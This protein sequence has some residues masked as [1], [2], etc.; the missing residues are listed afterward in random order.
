[1]LAALDARSRGAAACGAARVLLPARCGARRGA[2]RRP[3]RARPAGRGRA[4]RRLGA[5]RGRD[6][7]GRRPRRGERPTPSGSHSALGRLEE[8]ER[9]GSTGAAGARGRTHSG[10]PV[11]LRIAAPAQLGDLWQHG[12]GSAAHNAALRERAVRTRAAR[13]GV[14][15]RRRRGGATRTYATEAEVYG[16]LGLPYIEPELRED[17]GELEAQGPA[18]PHRAGRRA[19]RPALPHRR[20]R[21]PRH[22]RGDG[23]RGPGARVRV[24][25]DHRPLR[26]ARLRQRRLPD[27]AAHADRA[28]ARG[29]TRPWRGCGCWRAPRST[30]CPTAR[31]TTRTHC[32]PSWTGWWRASTP[33][34]AWASAR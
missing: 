27:A 34:S 3:A 1:M 5:A 25:G 20:L 11:D 18:P 22:D 13:V 6:R 12:T 10:V 2:R 7:Q 16:A 19:R 21:R 30:S 14:R 32:S 33:R 8:I 4:A 9:V 15:D 24:P 28:G 31:W 26:L 23:R 17:R 29:S